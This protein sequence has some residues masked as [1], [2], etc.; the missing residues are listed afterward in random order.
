MAG[1]GIPGPAAAV[2]RH[3]MARLA[4]LAAAAPVPVSAQSLPS[5]VEVT[6]GGAMANTGDE[7]VKVTAAR[8]LPDGRIVVAIGDPIEVRV[9]SPAGTLLDRIGRRGGGPGEFRSIVSIPYADDDSIVTYTDRY[10]RYEVF[11]PGGKLIHEYTD[12]LPARAPPMLHRAIL[13]VPDGVAN[14][15][16]RRVMLSLPST[17]AADLHEVIPDRSGHL[18]AH[19]IGGREWRVYSQAGPLQ[20]TVMLPPGSTVFDVGA[21]Y[22]LTESHDAD[23]F[24][25]VVEYRVALPA[26]AV[27]PP[28]AAGVESFPHASTSAPRG[29]QLTRVLQQAMVANEVAYSDLAHYPRSADSLRLT[30]PAETVLRVIEASNR[31]YADA[32]LDARSTLFCVVRVGAGSFNWPEAEV[33]CAQ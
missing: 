5:R 13:L 27:A 7:L 23:G 10:A 4:L 29:A 17:P 16:A 8:R 19:A 25:Q 24:E 21:G 12:T 26:G 15:C 9:Y 30:L 20:G 22:L 1:R 6:I 32:V 14:G 31:G 18:W 2:A 33:F 28:C 11:R 3:R